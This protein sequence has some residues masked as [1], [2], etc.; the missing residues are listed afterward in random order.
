MCGIFGTTADG[1]VQKTLQALH[2]LEYRG[3]DSAGM[4]VKNGSLQVFKTQGR[5]SVLE[6]KL[7][8][9]VAG[10]SATGHTRW[11]THG[12]VCDKNAHPFLS[13]DGA[14]SI[15]HNGILENYVSLKTQLQKEGFTFV[16]DTDSETI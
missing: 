16:S 1:C 4:C 10:E 3:Y 5:V 9:N 12:E 13:Q 11:A 14:F 7:P 8:Q 15:C 6:G 2:F